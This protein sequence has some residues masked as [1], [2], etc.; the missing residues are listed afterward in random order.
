[1]SET[2]RAIANSI[3]K[4]KVNKQSINMVFKK[5]ISFF[6]DNQQFIGKALKCNHPNMHLLACI[7]LK[8][9]FEKNHYTFDIIL[10]LQ[11]IHELLIDNIL[12][13]EFNNNDFASY[14]ATFFMLD[15]LCMSFYNPLSIEKVVNNFRVYVLY[16]KAMQIFNTS[17]PPSVYICK[18]LEVV[19]LV[20]IICQD[21]LKYIPK[22]MENLEASISFQEINTIYITS[23]LNNIIS[24]YP[25]I[26][27]KYD[28]KKLMFKLIDYQYTPLDTLSN[29]FDIL[30]NI[31]KKIRFVS[32]S[33]E[34]LMKLHKI[35]NIKEANNFFEI[36]T[37]TNNDG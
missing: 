36:L 6:I 10:F 34:E 24:Q 13:F 29:V 22:I 19:S 2:F 32:Y 4:M 27:V 9:I 37:K 7:V 5:N 11:D 20:P 14:M 25:D 35:T 8:D 18:I 3:C 15:V 28:M 21:L 31:A 23:L 12:Q 33:P 17:K 26:F 30:S 16:E 1:M